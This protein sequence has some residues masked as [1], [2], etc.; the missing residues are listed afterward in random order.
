MVDLWV[1]GFPS[2]CGF[3]LL[4]FSPDTH[5]PRERLLYC[6]L[7]FPVPSFI[8]SSFLHSLGKYLLSTYQV[9]GT[10]PGA[11][12]PEMNKLEKLKTTLG[13]Q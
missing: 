4:S 1:L 3:C 10:G 8:H 6:F 9:L 7:T 11:G 12:N 5:C 2:E 13:A